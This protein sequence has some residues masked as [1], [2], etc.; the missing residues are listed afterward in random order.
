MPVCFQQDNPVGCGKT[1]QKVSQKQ[2]KPQKK[3]VGISGN[4]KISCV[5]ITGKAD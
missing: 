4:R 5:K 3:P 1:S 2:N